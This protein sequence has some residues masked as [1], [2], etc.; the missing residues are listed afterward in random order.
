MES[1]R[2]RLKAVVMVAAG[3]M[4]HGR[5]RVRSATADLPM[6]RMAHLGDRPGD[7]S[8]AVAGRSTMGTARRRSDDGGHLGKRPDPEARLMADEPEAI[9]KVLDALLPLTP[10][11]RCRV[12]RWAT[13]W[14]SD[15]GGKVAD[16]ERDLKLYAALPEGEWVIVRGMLIKRSG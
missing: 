13:W 14:V 1:T 2:I 11:M 12:V 5:T 6:D 10:D 3:L 7:S 8:A 9:R 15:H 16:D 4:F